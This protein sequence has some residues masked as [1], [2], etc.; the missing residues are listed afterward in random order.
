MR[1][2]LNAVP[3]YG[4][5]AGAR[6]YT[7]GLLKA[8]SASDADMEWHVL[9]RDADFDALGIASDTRFHRIPFLGPAAPP[10]LPGVR[11][12]WRNTLD[13]VALPLYGRRY[14]V[15]H[16]LDTYG[17]LMSPGETPLALTV[18]DLFPITNPE[19]FS[20]W[21]A[22]YLASLMRAIPRASG[23]MAISAATARALTTVF[24][25][26]TDR[27]RIVHNG[28]DA[29]FHP[30]TEFERNDAVRRYAIEG[31]YLIAVGAVER[32]KNLARVVRAFARA[33]REA[34]LPHQLLIAGKRGWGYDEVEMAIAETGMGD[35]VRL[36]G[37]LPA[38]EIP[39]LISGAD[40]L[41]HLSLA[42]GFGLPV[43][44]GMACGAPVLTSSTS[45]LAEV[46]GGAAYVVDPL[47]EDAI[48]FALISLCQDSTLRARLRAASLRQA[49]QFS[50]SHVADAAIATYR[51][52]AARRSGRFQSYKEYRE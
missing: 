47:D 41:V 50:W 37:Y 24:G 20:P 11:F 21:V 42:E 52:A 45:A 3:L 49:R 36:L 15:T 48:T 43:I 23:L 40:A 12:V 39:Q 28:V 4:K 7:A 5:G 30:A 16:F 25:I 10:N 29:R 6:T 9:L 46:A 1:V 18:H 14:D 33:R 31:P 2:L 17:P 35:V 38:R 44:E 13:Q 22:R 32:R 51:E 26:T 34:H 8:L 27:I 19:Y